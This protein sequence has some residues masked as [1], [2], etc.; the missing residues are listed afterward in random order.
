MVKPLHLE[1]MGL[2]GNLLAHRLDQLGLE[3]TWHDASTRNAWRASTGLVYSDEDERSQV[4]LARWLQQL[5][6]PWLGQFAEECAFVYT[7]KN[8][9]HGARYA[10]TDLGA[11]RVA[12]RGNAVAVNVAQLVQRGQGLRRERRTAAPEP[13]ERLVRAHGFT[14]RLGSVSWGWSARVRLDTSAVD[15]HCGGLRPVFYSRNGR[16]QMVYAYPS[17]GTEYWLAGSVMVNQRQA[18]DVPEPMVLRHLDRWVEA[19]RKLWPSIPL[20]SIGSPVQGWRPRPAV[21]GDSEVL[22]EGGVITLPAL[23]HSGVR[24]SPQVIDQAIERI[25]A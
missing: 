2:L 23:W 17:P 22:D 8:P 4:G 1:G 13:W 21:Q 3:Y 15:A 7:H 11:M 14:E 12:P 5:N 20:L 24:W 10:A 16:F 9:P 18:H 6:D 25:T 19:W